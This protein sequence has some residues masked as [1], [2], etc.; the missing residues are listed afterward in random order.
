MPRKAQNLTK[1]YS[2]LDKEI[3]KLKNFTS[4]DNLLNYNKTISTRAGLGK[5]SYKF[6]LKNTQ[7]RYSTIF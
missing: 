4:V 6:S 7:S 5:K 1:P 3:K 2:T